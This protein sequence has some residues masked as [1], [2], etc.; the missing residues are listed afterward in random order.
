MRDIVRAG[1]YSIEKSTTTVYLMRRI[2]NDNAFPRSYARDTRASN[3]HFTGL[4]KR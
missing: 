2:N 1:L 4:I 3:P